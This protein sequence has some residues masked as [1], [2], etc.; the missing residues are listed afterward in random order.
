VAVTSDDL[1]D[2][3]WA[4]SELALVQP[5]GVGVDDACL[6]EVWTVQCLTELE[7]AS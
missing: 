4:E 6:D 7:A 1:D 3:R 2:R 5:D